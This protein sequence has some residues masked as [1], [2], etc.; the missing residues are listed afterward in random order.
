MILADDLTDAQ[1][2]AFR[3]SVNKMSEFA[4]WDVELLKLEFAGPG[5]GGL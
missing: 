2:K 4:E 1:I 3:L 5:R